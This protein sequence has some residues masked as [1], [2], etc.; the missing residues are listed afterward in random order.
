MVELVRPVVLFA[1]SL[2]ARSRETETERTTLGDKA[3]RFVTEGMLGLVSVHRFCI[4][5]HRGLSRQRVT[6]WIYEDRLHIE[7]QQTVLARY[8]ATLNRRRKWLKSVFQPQTS[9][10]PFVSPQLEMF[11]L[12][13]EQW[14]RAWLCPPYVHRKPQDSLAR[15]LSLLALDILL[16]LV[17]IRG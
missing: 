10:T 11:E 4:F 13:E 1:Q 17:P 8:K 16:W 12:D 2:A 14:R 9:S 15:Q 3:R 7:Y 6:V 5:A